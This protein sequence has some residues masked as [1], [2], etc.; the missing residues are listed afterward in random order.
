MKKRKFKE[1][2][3]I[4]FYDISR[5]IIS[6]WKKNKIFE[7]SIESR[8]NSEIFSFYE[9][10]PSAN[11]LPG[12]HHVMAR[13]VKDIFC[14]YKTL[15]GYKVYRKGGWDTHGLPVELQVEQKLGITKDDIGEKISVEKYNKECKKAVMKFKKKWEE[16]TESIGFW[17]DINDAYITFE[18][19][20]IESVWWSIKK[21]YDKKLLYKGYTIQPYSP[22]AGT[23]LSSHELNMPG[24]YKL[25]K[26]TSLVAQFRIKINEKSKLIFDDYNDIFFLA[27][28][29]TPWTLPA[30]NGLAVGKKINYVLL[31]TFN[32]YSGNRIKIVI[33]ENCIEKVFNIK[34]EQ[35]NNK[36]RFDKNNIQ[37]KI[38]KK[39]KGNDLTGLEYEQLLPYVKVEKPAFSVVEGDFVSTEEGTGIVHL[40]LT[41]G[42]DDFYLSKKNNL[43]G[44]FVRDKNS[45]LVPIVNKSGKFVDEIKDFAGMEVKNF[46]Q[47]NDNKNLTTDEKIAI[48]LK[49]ENKAFDVKKHEHSYPH[50]WR[51]DKPILYYPLESWF[52][53]TTKLKKA[54]IEANKK[55][56]WQPPSTGSGRFGNWLENLVDWNLSRSRFW[57]TPL[58]IWRTKDGKEEFCIGSINQLNDEVSKSYKKGFMKNLLSEDFDLH[59]PYVDDI[60]LVSKKG[61]PMYRE[62]DIIDVW[63]DSGAVPFAQYHYPFENENLFNKMFP[64]NFIAEGV[65]QTRGWFFT[66]HAISVMLFDKSS[67]ENVISN[68]LVLDKDGNKMSKRLGN[69]VDPYEVI[70]K[71][72]PDA[73]RL[74]MIINSNPWDNL[75]FDSDGINEVVRK[76]F[77]TLSNT[78]SF[79]ALYANIDGFN[80]NEEF[81]PYKKRNFDDRWIISKLNT[82]IKAVEVNLNEYSPTKAARIINQFLNDDLSNWYVR[83]NRKRFWKG[84]LL[85][86]KLMAYQTL[87]ECLKKIS[88]ISSPFIPFYSEKLFC[89]LNEFSN[90][91]SESVHISNYP[92]SEEKLISHSIERKMLYAQKISSLVHSIR[93]KEKIKVRQPLSAILIPVNSKEVE[94]DVRA[95]E[96]I[97]LSEVNVKKVKYV[98]DNSKVFI[99]KIKPNYKKLGSLYGAKMSNVSKRIMDMS[100]DEINML[101]KNGVIELNID[102]NDNIKLKI[103]QAE[104]SFSDIEGQLVA[105][106]DLFTI[107]LE[108]SINEALL[109][110][111]ISREFI[112]KIQNERKNMSLEVTDK[113]DIQVENDSS[114]IL[115]YINDHKSFICNETQSIGLKFVDNLN[116]SKTMEIKI[117]HSNIN[118]ETVNYYI[119]KK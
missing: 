40:S 44:V 8:S 99:K 42:S 106:N 6:F 85:E 12:I 97:I 21:L 55:I 111:G 101:E 24:A 107:A 79:F 22:A 96:K 28:T 60:V 100:Q 80:G 58:P 81:I 105:S 17:L 26:D 71:Y 78:Y 31:D 53:N 89:D 114:A 43:P 39:F 38:L 68:G 65:D 116:N 95:V 73:T 76:F 48:K 33:A 75:K 56:N 16:L 86:D 84:D 72:G 70:K 41:F 14:R 104:I 115:K 36:L 61:S 77:G 20:Y 15:Q 109:S 3:S 29:T 46:S 88:I 4:N 82:T 50:C 18:N 49:K 13:T 110:E 83:L 63:Y 74:Y 98:Y 11:G 45:E 34:N 62:K 52:I 57:G 35:I 1:Y 23:G 103:D 91:K 32:K 19:N 112:N 119:I 66:L 118:S 117:N 2:E 92:S 67:F 7:K 87:H 93:K 10:P 108:I 54:L 47:K 102:D 30:N 25:I 37:Y 51:T 94:K 27:W 113:I 59:K 9:G 69:A 64:A 5:E 90:N